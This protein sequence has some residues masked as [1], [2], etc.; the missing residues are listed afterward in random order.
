MSREMFFLLVFEGMKCV[1][2][3]TCSRKELKSLT[4]VMDLSYVLLRLP[5]V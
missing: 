3:A 5:V 2:G 1:E 4:Y